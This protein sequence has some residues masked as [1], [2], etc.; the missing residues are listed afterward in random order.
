MG[1][2]PEQTTCTPRSQSRNCLPKTHH[3]METKETD[4]VPSQGCSANMTSR[5]S[6]LPQR[7]PL[8]RSSSAFSTPSPTRRKVPYQGPIARILMRSLKTMATEARNP[9]QNRKALAA[10]AP[11]APLPQTILHAAPTMPPKSLVHLAPRLSVAQH[12]KTIIPMARTG[13]RLR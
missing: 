9:R 8:A 5:V 10:T 1:S 3:A 2:C 4:T 13:I 7:L 6:A 12:L 11:T